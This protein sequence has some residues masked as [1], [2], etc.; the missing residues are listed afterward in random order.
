MLKVG[1]LILWSL[2]F[3]YWIISMAY[4]ETE[5]KISWMLIPAIAPVIFPFYIVYR[6]V[7]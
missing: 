2:A 4:I 1:E 7:K 6:L 3:I 5:L